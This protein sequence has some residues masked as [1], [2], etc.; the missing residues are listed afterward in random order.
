MTASVSI[1]IPQSQNFALLN[2]RQ[3]IH[4]SFDFT[5]LLRS[6]TEL[7]RNLFLILHPTENGPLHAVAGAGTVLGAVSDPQGRDRLF[8]LHAGDPLFLVLHLHL[9]VYVLR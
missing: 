8:S 7:L 6:A 4:S 9:E 2:I 5:H 3:G 1:Q